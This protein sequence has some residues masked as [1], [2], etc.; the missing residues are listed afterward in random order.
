M[1]ITVDIPNTQDVVADMV[2]AE[3]ILLAAVEL[4]CCLGPG[5]VRDQILTRHVRSISRI[6]HSVHRHYY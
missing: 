3:S 1:F 2:R 4:C 6:V 5:I